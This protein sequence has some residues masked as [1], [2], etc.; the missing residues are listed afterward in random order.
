M[1]PGASNNIVLPGDCT[2]REKKNTLQTCCGG[3]KPLWKSC[4]SQ[5]GSWNAAAIQVEFTNQ[6]PSCVL[7]G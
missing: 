3:R 6:I 7:L 2:G 1:L 4:C 5:A